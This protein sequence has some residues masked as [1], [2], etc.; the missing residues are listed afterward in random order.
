MNLIKIFLNFKSCFQC[1]FLKNWGQN[2][3]YLAILKAYNIPTL[4]NKVERYYNNI[5]IRIFRVIGCISSLLVISKLYLELSMGLPLLCTILASFYITHVFII[6]ILKSVYSFQI[7]LFK[8]EQF[9]VMNL[10]YASVISLAF[11]Y[12]KLCCIGL[13]VAVSFCA[14]ILAYDSLLVESGRD[15]VFLRIIIQVYTEYLEHLPFKVCL[16]PMLSLVYVSFTVSTYYLYYN[17][18]YLFVVFLEFV[19]F[20]LFVVMFMLLKL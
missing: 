12:L 18:A 13:V 2:S 11:Y 15:I 16:F 3:I 10:P 17:R 7:I 5:F 1:W 6:Y 4:P 14:G 9:E 19:A 20:C 8:K